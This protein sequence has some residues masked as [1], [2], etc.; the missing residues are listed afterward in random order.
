MRDLQL[1]EYHQKQVRTAMVDGEVCFVAKDVCDVLEITNVSDAIRRL[2]E[3]E[4]GIV[5]TDTPS[6]NQE[7]LIVNES[8]LYSLI[9]GSRKPEAKPLRSPKLNWR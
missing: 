8:G 4:K 6:G 5:S 3:D 7:M 2:D 1:F 9:L